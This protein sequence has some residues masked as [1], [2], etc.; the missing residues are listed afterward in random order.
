MKKRKVG[1]FVG[2]WGGGMWVGFLGSR[3]L[4]LNRKWESRMIFGE[5][6]RYFYVESFC[7]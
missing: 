1:R 7:F 3:N 6:M 4:S 2:G 5:D